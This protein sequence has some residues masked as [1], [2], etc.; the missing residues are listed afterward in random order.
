MANI[1]I[2]AQHQAAPKGNYLVGR[3]TG[4]E[5][6]VV[7]GQPTGP[8]RALLRQCMATLLKYY[9]GYI[10]DV[11]VNAGVIKILN[12]TLSGKYG[13]ILRISDYATSSELDRQLI[14]AGGEILERFRLKA[15]RR[16]EDRVQNLDRDF[17][18]LP[19]FDKD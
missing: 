13:F 17:L 16:N 10:W 11:H 3:T 14:R 6:H 19:T 2:P 5:M 1:H 7:Q 15:T 18:G 8:E 12:Q 4:F 9:G